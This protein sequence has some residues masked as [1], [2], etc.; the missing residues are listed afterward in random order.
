MQ[1]AEL[2][3]LLCSD[4]DVPKNLL[5]VTIVNW[6]MMATPQLLDELNLG[7]WKLKSFSI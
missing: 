2:A 7:F 1:G 5:P 4:G 6:L 3:L